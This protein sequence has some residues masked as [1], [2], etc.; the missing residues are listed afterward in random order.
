MLIRL[1]IQQYVMPLLPPAPPVAPSFSLGRLK[2]AI[3]RLYLA[4]EPAYLPFLIR[5]HRL[6]TWQDWN[7]SCIWCSVRALSFR[8]PSALTSFSLT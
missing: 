6:A 2:M 8:K 3:E 1:L 4:V 7:T 5:I